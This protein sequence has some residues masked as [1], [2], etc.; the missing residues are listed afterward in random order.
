[1]YTEDELRLIWQELEFLT[2]SSKLEEAGVY[3]GAAK[4]HVGEYQS[5]AKVLLLDSVY[6]KR[7]YSNI[8]TV[9]RKLFTDGFLQIYSELSP[10]LKF[11]SLV[12]GDVT[13]IRYYQDGE[14]FNPHSDMFHCYTAL[15][16]FYKEPKQFSGGELFFPLHDY[17]FDCEHNS[18]ILFQGYIEHAVKEVKIDEIP[19]SGN[20]RYCMTQFLYHNP[21]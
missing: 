12:N 10:E 8:L 3:A 7:E 18:M 9:N 4:N 15:S 13:K 6:Q 21:T 16:Y 17:E 11:V 5:N 19:F 14:Y 1:M 20:S 2:Y